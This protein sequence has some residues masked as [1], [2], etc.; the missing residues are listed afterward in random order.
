MRL[1]YDSEADAV[2]IRLDETPTSRIEEVSDV[3]IVEYG[4]AG[5][6]VAI[7][8]LS[9]FGFA[10]AS[11]YALVH[12]GLLA[13]QDAERFLQALRHELVTA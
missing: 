11:L 8:L 12:K 1:E 5:N 3:C 13:R 7:E 2:Y 4:A 9:V 10:G 6:L